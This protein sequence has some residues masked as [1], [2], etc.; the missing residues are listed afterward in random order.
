MLHKRHSLS[1]SIMNLIDGNKDLL[2]HLN[3]CRKEA[4]T[5]VTSKT[6][7]LRK[8]KQK[9]KKG[10]LYVRQIVRSQV[11]YW[12]VIVFVFLNTL[13]IALEHYGQ[14]P[15]L[16]TFQETC[17]MV[18]LVIFITEMLLKMYGLGIHTYFSS[19]FNCFDFTVV[20]CGIL[21]M[22]I[23][24][25]QG[26]SL[27]ISVLRSLRLLRI[28]KV[29]RFWKSLR[30]LVTSLLNSVRSILSLIFLLLLFIFIFALLGMQ[31]FGAK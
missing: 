27:G 9:F 28:F 25:V 31:L 17:E 29:T 6:E 13:V 19:A 1:D 5:T 30:N 26:I 24:E 14:P 4:T 18:F 7:A 3:N 16:K 10:R 23:Q 12:S 15:F 11:F 21:E 8:I 22:I 2:N 20:L